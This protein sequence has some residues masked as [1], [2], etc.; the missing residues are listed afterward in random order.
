MKKQKMTSYWSVKCDP[1]NTANITKAMSQL[2]EIF[3]KDGVELVQ[4]NAPLVAAAMAE[5]DA[6]HPVK[7]AN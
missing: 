1:E 4:L 7:E 5:Y 2:G 6:M 3:R